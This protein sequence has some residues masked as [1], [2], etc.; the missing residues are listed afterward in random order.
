MAARVFLRRY[1]VIRLLG[2]GGM[3]CAYLASQSN[4]DRLVVVKT[5][6]EKK[7]SDAHYRGI[8][9]QEIDCLSRFRHPCAVELYE[10][11]M[12]GPDGPCAVMEYVDGEPLDLVLR[13]DGPFT[14]ARV[15]R[16][17]GR[18]CAVLQAAHDLGIVHRDLKPANLMVVGVGKADESLKVLDFGLARQIGD[19]TRGLYLPLEKFVGSRVHKAVGTPEYACP[20]QFRGDEVDHRGDLYSVGVIL[21]ELL[22]GRRPFQGTAP[23]E[24]IRDHLHTTP[25]PLRAHG[26]RNVPPVL[27]VLVS[28][29]LA[30]YPE[31]RPQ[32]ARELASC[33]G[34]V[35]GSSI[36]DEQEALAWDSAPAA[37]PANEP[38]GED[39][40]T[41]VFRLEAW[42]P[43]SIAAMK[44]RGFVDD[45]GEVSASAPGRLRVRLRMPRPAVASPRPSGFI[46]R[47]G[48]GRTAAPTPAV[49][50]VDADVFVE[51]EDASKPSELLITVRLHPPEIQSKEEA[52]RWLEWCKQIQM[53]LAAYLMARKVG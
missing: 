33:Y 37:A 6:H 27:E 14:L 20:E 35:L 38:E 53:D 43:Q 36:W 9:Q 52:F 19:P 2:Q 22:T 34:K 39:E 3:G 21:F 48:L 16:L 5:L 23:A 15:G 31:D 4:P 44:L 46:S 24:L 41:D 47:L 10:A 11:S 32:S 12:D 1:K 28:A 8:F 17:L 7:T 51:A 29:C 30:K 49:D 50:L 13:R 18:L 42:M 40:N 45:R 25:P 26:A